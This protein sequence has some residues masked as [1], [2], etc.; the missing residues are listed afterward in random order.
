M[1]VSQEGNYRTVDCV[2]EYIW[3]QIQYIAL[4]A[5]WV[6]SEATPVQGGILI[7]GVSQNDALQLISMI[8]ANYYIY[9]WLRNII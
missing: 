6:H 7:K 8:S 1:A 3:V 5:I 2:F 9:C 4:Q